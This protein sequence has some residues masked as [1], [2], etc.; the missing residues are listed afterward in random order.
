MF[1]KILRGNAIG[2]HDSVRFHATRISFGESATSYLGVVEG[3]RVSALVGEGTVLFKKSLDG[4][5]LRKNRNGRLLFLP[6]NYGSRLRAINAS[7]EFAFR[8]VNCGMIE[9]LIPT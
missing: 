4:H 9:V 2:S 6:R 5:K 8:R 7:G 3:D 1:R